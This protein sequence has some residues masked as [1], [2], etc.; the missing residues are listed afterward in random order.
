VTYWVINANANDFQVSATRG[1]AA[2]NITTDYSDMTAARLFRVVAS[3]DGV[4]VGHG[5]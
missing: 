4:D 3:I 1:G 2:V 5:T